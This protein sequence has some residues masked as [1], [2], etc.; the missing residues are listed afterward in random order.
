M[1]DDVQT[2]RRPYQ[3]KEQTSEGRMKRFHVHVGV[4]DLD[5]SVR[6]YST[7]F[8]VFRSSRSIA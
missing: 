5:E 3:S 7:L 2:G 4:D 8:R 1:R 6:F